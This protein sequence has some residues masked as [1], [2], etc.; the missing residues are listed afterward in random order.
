MS[1]FCIEDRLFETLRMQNFTKSNIE[2][3]KTKQLMHAFFGL[4][5]RERDR[6]FESKPLHAHN[7]P[8]DLDE[9]ELSLYN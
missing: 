5:H 8:L 9:S 4:R 2:M 6:L 7:F 1:N 3:K